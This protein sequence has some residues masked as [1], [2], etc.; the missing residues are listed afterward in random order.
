MYLLTPKSGSINVQVPVLSTATYIYI[1]M[2]ITQM[3]L[4]CLLLGYPGH[5]WLDI[6]TTCILRFV[7]KLIKA[8]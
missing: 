7:L 5:A 6:P 4:I 3:F 1:C 2:Y 8:I